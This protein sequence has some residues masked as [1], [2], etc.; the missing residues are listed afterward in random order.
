[1]Q[2]KGYTIPELMVLIIVI[3]IFSFVAIDKA[4]YAFED[5]TTNND[6][7]KEMILV[8]S[9][10]VYGNKKIDEV[11]ANTMYITG[12]DLVDAEYLIDEENTYTNA[13]IRLS[14]NKE[15]ESVEAEVLK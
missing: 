9:A 14:Y 2:N 3:G 6:Q 10:T 13:K 5:T 7:I 8:K 11:K 1:M 4:S 15:T 12:K